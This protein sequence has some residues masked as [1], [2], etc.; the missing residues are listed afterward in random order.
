M[1][2]GG[3]GGRQDTGENSFLTI[4]K[5]QM[6][7]ALQF[8]IGSLVTFGGTAFALLAVN[9]L[10]ITLGSIHLLI[11]LVGLFTGIFVATRKALPRNLLLG[12]NLLTIV[13]S[14]SSVSVAGIL[15]LL[16]SSAFH[17]SLIGT[18]AAVIMSSI[19]IYLLRRT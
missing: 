2:L 10:G 15:S 5:R 3:N 6:I 13:Y 12:A 7:I 4:G 1:T 16:P 19:V 17:D 9:G 14:V 11:G 18:A 8:L